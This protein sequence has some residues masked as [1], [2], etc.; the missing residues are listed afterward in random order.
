MV[1][2]DKAEVEKLKAE[3]SNLRKKKE[4]LEEANARLKELIEQLR[5]ENGM[6]MRE[7]REMLEECYVIR[8]EMPQWEP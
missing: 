3:A 1:E 7:V 5:L 4:E 2:E 8:E 6:L